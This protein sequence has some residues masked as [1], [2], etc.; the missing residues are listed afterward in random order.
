MGLASDLEARLRDFTAAAEVEVREN[1]G[2]SV[3]FSGLSWEIRGAA[4][5]PLLHLW[6]ENYNVTRRVLAIT[7]HSDERLALAVECFGRK[8]P[9]RLEF[10]RV[11]FQRSVRDLSREEFC[12]RLERILG[13]QFPDETLESLTVAP[14]LGHSLSGNYARGILRRGSLRW[15]VLG[16]PAG[17]S[18]EAAENSLTFALLWLERARE[19]ARRGIVTGV[20]V[21]VPKGTGSIVGHR[22]PALRA[23]LS[24][25][26]YEQ[27]PV[28]ETLERLDP[29]ALGN[30]ESRLVPYRETQLLVDRAR[31]ALDSVIALSPQ[32]LTVHPSVPTREVWVR[33]QGLAVARW[34]DGRIFFGATNSQEELTATSRPRLQPWLKELESYRHPLASDTRHPLYRAQPERWLEA[35]VAKDV[36]LIDAALDP[37]FVYSQVF[38]KSGGEHRILDLLCVTRR[39]RLAILELKAN[40]HIHLPLQAAAYWL[41]I[42]QH[43]EEG[44]FARLGYFPGVE[45]QSK[46]PLVYLV[47]PALRF[48]P[49]TDV[50]LR[51]LSP[52]MEA[53]RVGIAENWRR[54]I[55]VVIRQ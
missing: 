16:A 15:A 4:E 21:I 26:L 37:R 39:G 25:E 47:A 53:V 33:F 28:S 27:D 46:P 54:G 18:A 32:N 41:R 50:L 30:I 42:R 29:A 2:R 13:E 1:G 40:E 48:H 6:S 35:T 9:E 36:T 44:D 12:G 19:S 8:K 23:E 20:R 51:H 10:V 55:S 5:K 7:D 31:P 43:L 17:E 49:A 22:I 38:A 3:P 45:L 24:I 34:E 14:D 11:E 52:E